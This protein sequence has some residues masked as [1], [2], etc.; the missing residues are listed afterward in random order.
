VISTEKPT[1]KAILDYLQIK[2]YLYWRVNTTGVYDPTKKIFRKKPAHSRN[3]VADIFVLKKG[4]SYFIEVKGQKGVLS[5]DQKDFRD[6]VT[7]H[8]GI[9]IVA[10]SIDDVIKAGL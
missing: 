10:K 4:V 6:D 1:Q 5:Q 8:G 9:F 2:Q 7:K 3:G